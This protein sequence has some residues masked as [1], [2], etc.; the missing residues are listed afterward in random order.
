MSDRTRYVVGEARG[1][2]FLRLEEGTKELK[3]FIAPAA[4]RELARK[5]WGSAAAVEE[6]AAQLAKK[7]VG[8]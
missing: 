3:V 7:A 1:A 6:E 2:V 4:A 5:L 8:S